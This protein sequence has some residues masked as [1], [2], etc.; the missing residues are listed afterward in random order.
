M[1]LVALRGDCAMAQVVS[2]RPLTAETRVRTRLSACRVRGGQC[3]TCTGFS[4][5]S[6][7]LA[8]QYYST[9]VALLT[10]IDY[11]PAAEQ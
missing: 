10:H 3:G 8:C 6:S 9:V 5:S 4:L 2:R 1:S 7:V 11:H